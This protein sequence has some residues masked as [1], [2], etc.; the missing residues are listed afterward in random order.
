MTGREAG[1]VMK[2]RTAVAY[3]ALSFRS[4]VAFSAAMCT[5]ENTLD[6]IHGNFFG[7]SCS[8]VHTGAKPH[9]SER[10]PLATNDFVH[11]MKLSL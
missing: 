6:E 5:F 2:V 9:D 4:S 10:V 7:Q 1:P 8:T 3:E 11:S